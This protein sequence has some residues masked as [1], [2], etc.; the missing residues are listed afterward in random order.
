[1][2][3]ARFD[4]PRV[5]QVLAITSFANPRIKDIRALDMPKHRK[6]R[7]VFV[8]EGLKLVT[9]ALAGNWPIEAFVYG[10]EVGDQQAVQNAA[11]KARA[12]GADVLSVSTAILSK[13]VHRDNPQMVLGVFGQKL[14]Q[15]S[16]VKP[17]KGGVWVVLETPRDPGN[18]GTI[19]RTVDAVGADGVVLV[20]PSV[21]PFS[22]EAVRATMGSIFH[23]PIARMTE[24]EFLALR[25]AWPGTVVG[26]HLSGAVDYRKADYST[27]VLLMMGNEQSGLTERLAAAADQLVRIPQAG[28][29]DSLNL[30]VATA[31]TLF[32]IRRPALHIAPEETP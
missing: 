18:L 8:A 10:T 9:D 2:T 23:V 3:N 14:A 17:G 5:G 19:V 27:P 31:V 7:G 24:G 30:A 26:T 28:R 11:A 21:D 32:E 20:G 22:T 13:M 1:M 6:E 25:A 12:R 4:R 16:D 29:A 15:A